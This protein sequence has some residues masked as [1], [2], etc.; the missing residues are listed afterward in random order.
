MIE[1][2]PCSLCGDTLSCSL[3]RLSSVIHHLSIHHLSM[4]PCRIV[5]FPTVTKKRE[6]RCGVGVHQDRH[7]DATALAMAFKACVNIKGPLHV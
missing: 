7:E 2:V 3:L 1:S 4:H 6:G 5:H